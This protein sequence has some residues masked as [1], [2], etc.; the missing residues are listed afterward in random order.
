MGAEEGGEG[1]T[2]WDWDAVGVGVL[3]DVTGEDVG[4]QDVG[5]HWG[6]LLILYSLP[7]FQADPMHILDR[8]CLAIP[9]HL[10]GASHS[11]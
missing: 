9:A 11:P 2:A 4:F 10:H 8:P 3:A 1:G 7:P 6:A 5:G